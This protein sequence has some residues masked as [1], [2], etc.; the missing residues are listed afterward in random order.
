[1]AAYGTTVTDVGGGGYTLQVLPG[2]DA[3]PNIYLGFP[4]PGAVDPISVSASTYY[5]HD[6]ILTSLTVGP[7]YTVTLTGV[8]ANAVTATIQDNL[9]T[10]VSPSCTG[11]GTITCTATLG[12]SATY[13]IV[14]VDGSTTTAGAAYTVTATAPTTADPGGTGSFNT[15]YSGYVNNSIATPW[16]YDW[17]AVAGGSYRV[18]AWVADPLT[19]VLLED[20]GIPIGSGSCTAPDAGGNLVCDYTTGTN[21]T[22]LDV[23]VDASATVAGSDFTLTVLQPVSENILTCSLGVVCNTTGINSTDTVSSTYE[24]PVVYP[25]TTYTLTLTGV[26]HPNVTASYAFGDTGA[27]PCGTAV[28]PAGT[29]TCMMPSGSLSAG[30]NLDVYV[31]GTGTVNG[32]F[33]TLRIQ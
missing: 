10:A 33:Y 12:A 24:V 29:L 17:T 13:L 28:S 7:V 16:T 2:Y 19:A 27:T 4:Y 8:T 18:L 6:W 14:T 23:S 15:P 1:V 32:A 22:V 11:S 25:N 31:N 9:G 20:D 30:S 26:T 5:I 3:G 21:A